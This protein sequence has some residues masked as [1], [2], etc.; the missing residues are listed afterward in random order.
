MSSPV[1]SAH[2]ASVD[3]KC[4]LSIHGLNMF[5]NP[6]IIGNH[7]AI[8]RYIIKLESLGKYDSLHS[9]TMICVCW[10]MLDIL[11]SDEVTLK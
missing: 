4:S 3:M 11:T 9:I 1:L 10:Q 8:I 7:L 5:L 2:V 6:K